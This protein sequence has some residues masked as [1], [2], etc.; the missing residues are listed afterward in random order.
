MNLTKRSELRRIPA[1]GCHDWATINRIL[2]AG[3]LAHVGFS[4]RGQLMTSY[5]AGITLNMGAAG[6]AVSSPEGAS[7]ICISI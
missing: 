1:R 2:D 6:H 3:F 4:V 5:A 7:D